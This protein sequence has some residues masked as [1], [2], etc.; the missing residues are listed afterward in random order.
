MFAALFPS[1]AWATE[2]VMPIGAV[3]MSGAGAAAVGVAGFLC[4]KLYGTLKGGELG[5]AWQ[6]VALALLFL[7]LTM[8]LDTL[9]AAGWLAVPAYVNGLL[10]LLAAAGLVLSFVRFA[11]VFK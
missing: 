6:S 7:A 3:F 11:R 9:A 10:K 1:A 5:A 4:F 2:A 8:I